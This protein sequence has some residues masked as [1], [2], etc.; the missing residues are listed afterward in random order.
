[1]DIAKTET[2]IVNAARRGLDIA[3]AAGAGS[4]K[5]I[6]SKECISRAA[7]AFAELDTSGGGLLPLSAL[8]PV[9]HE[10]GSDFSDGNIEAIR[11]ELEIEMD[12]LLSLPET[13]DIA[14]YLLSNTQQE[15][16]PDH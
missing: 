10:L 13:V 14:T 7:A 6:L 8:K 16:D 4:L 2:R 15:T 9:F 1:M 3:P 12:T 11:L 5:D